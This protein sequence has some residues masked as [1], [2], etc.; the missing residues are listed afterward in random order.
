[1]RRGDQQ[2]SGP[3]S[4]G[5]TQGRDLAG[6]GPRDCRRAGRRGVE[7]LE[8]SGLDSPVMRKHG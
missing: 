3:L 7:A 4:E 6:E 8:V 1:M 5:V 2:G